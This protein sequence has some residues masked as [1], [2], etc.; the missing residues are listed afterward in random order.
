MSGI[1]EDLVEQV[2][3]PLVEGAL[4]TYWFILA[5]VSVYAIFLVTS[6]RVKEPSSARRA[7]LASGVASIVHMWAFWTVFGINATAFAWHGQF[8]HPHRLIRIGLESSACLFVILL[9]LIPRNLICRRIQMP[10]AFTLSIGAAIAT[11]YSDLLFVLWAA[12]P[13]R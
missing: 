9:L 8:I 4:S 11:V 6:L 10:T 7:F 1:D 2:S 13:L 3:R 12:T 5:A